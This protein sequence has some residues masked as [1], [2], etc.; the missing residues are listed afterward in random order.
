M[1]SP[2][3]GVRFSFQTKVL[4]PVLAALVILPIVT[5]WL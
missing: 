4:V 2:A 5:L 3:P 1:S